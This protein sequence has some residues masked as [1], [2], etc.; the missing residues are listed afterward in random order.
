MRPGPGR[1]HVPRG[2]FTLRI[3]AVPQKSNV[4]GKVTASK[5][6]G[7]KLTPITTLLLNG[8]QNFLAQPPFQV[9][10]QI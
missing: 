8:A 2:T 4:F 3:D 10:Y 5:K 7:D 9:T 6:G 1:A